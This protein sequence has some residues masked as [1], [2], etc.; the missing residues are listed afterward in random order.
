MTN[1]NHAYQLS[2]DWVCKR[3]K[4]FT[5]S[6]L[7]KHLFEVHW[8]DVKKSIPRIMQNLL[9]DGKIKHHSFLSQKSARN[10]LDVIRV[11]ISVNYSAKQANN[12]KNDKSTLEINFE[13]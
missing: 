7:K 4:P 3:M 8:V 13:D 2:V 5:S 12:A 6:D 10:K 9:S 11:W 1:Y